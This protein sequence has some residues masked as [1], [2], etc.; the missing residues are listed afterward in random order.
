LHAR[1]IKKFDGYNVIHNIVTENLEIIG[2]I[3]EHPH[4]I[5]KH[6]N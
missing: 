1:V 5:E 3:Y 6:G 2:N 4:L